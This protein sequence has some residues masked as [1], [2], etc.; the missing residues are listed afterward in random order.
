MSKTTHRLLPPRRALPARV[1]VWVS[2]WLCAGMLG[3]AWG[4]DLMGAYEAAQVQDATIRAARAAT[5]AARERLPQAKAQLLPN[6]SFSASRNSNDLTRTQTNF[7]GQPSTTDEQYFSHNQSLQ[8]RQPLYRKALW[9][10]Y[11]QAE[12]V[13]QDAEAA[14][15]KESQNV[16]VKVAGAYMELLLA[17]DQLALV[18]KEQEVATRQ[19]DAAQKSLRGGTGTRT[20]IDEVQARLDMIRAQTLEARQHVAYTQHQLQTLVN[21]PVTEVAPLVPGKMRLEPPA[22]ATL[23]EW[24]ALAEQSSPELMSLK[25]RL[26]AARL[27]VDKA[28]AGHYPT[29]DAVAQITR[30]GSENVT[31][32]SSSYTNRSVGL[33]LNVP[34]YAGGY[35]SAAVRQALAEQTRAEEQLEAARRD[36]AVRLHREFRGVMEGVLK[37]RAREQAV[38]SAEQAVTSNRRSFSAGFRTVIDVLNAEQQLQM[39]QRDL[40]RERYTY[41]VSRVRLHALAGG[42]ETEVLAEVNGWLGLP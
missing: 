3:P 15:A 24:L 9:A 21:E 41:V 31:S 18:L 14:L 34:I 11:A 29:L 8:L 16:G 22:P 19:L 36:L 2:A 4:L 25:A 33:Q 5:D 32:P 38:K 35:A 7:L 17:Q 39:A 40:A 10:G 13:V 26:E 37:V 20:D 42:N 23:D 27:E 6:V 30:S 1:S 12:Y 28:Q